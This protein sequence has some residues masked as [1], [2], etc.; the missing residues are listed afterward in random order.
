MLY[1]STR[2]KLITATSAEAVLRGIAPDGGLYL[3]E[4]FDGTKIDLASVLKM[5]SNEISA[6]ILAVFQRRKIFC[7]EKDLFKTI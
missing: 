4:S 1:Y 6:E 3:P 5:T 2:N 7:G